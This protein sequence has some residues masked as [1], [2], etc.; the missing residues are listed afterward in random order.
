MV[1]M[2]VRFSGCPDR[3]G[4]W[5]DFSHVVQRVKFV[6]IEGIVDIRGVVGGGRS[7]LGGLCELRPS[8]EER[9]SSPTKESPTPG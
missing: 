9:G 3:G 8:Q 6:T 7:V 4:S 1:G 5:G 2:G